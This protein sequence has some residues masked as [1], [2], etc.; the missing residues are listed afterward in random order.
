MII[1]IAGNTASGKDQVVNRMER[2]FSLVIDADKVGHFIFEKKKIILRHLFG[3][4]NRYEI[5]QIVFRNPEQMLL[6]ESLIQPELRAFIVRILEKYC[7]GKR[8][9]DQDGHILINCAL[10][11]KFN[12]HFFCDAV[13]VVDADNEIRYERLVRFRGIQPEHA[14]NMINMQTPILQYK[15]YLNYYIVNNGNLDALFEKTDIFLKKL[16]LIRK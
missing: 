14:R 13:V 16:L 4:E 7:F 2:C 1:G 11:F 8:Q 9:G 3:T 6:L 10:L 5:S 12:L 15:K